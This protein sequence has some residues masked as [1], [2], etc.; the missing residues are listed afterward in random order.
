MNWNVFLIFL[1]LLN[2][3]AGMISDNYYFIVFGV[4][5]LIGGIIIHMDYINE[6]SNE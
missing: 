3:M 4:G 6:V 5:I 2:V 1:V